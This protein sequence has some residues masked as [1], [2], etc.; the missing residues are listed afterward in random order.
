VRA[1]I[2]TPQREPS[3]AVTGQRS[4][5][6]VRKRRLEEPE[7]EQRERNEL[8]RKRADAKLEFAKSL[9]IM[10][11][12]QRDFQSRMLQMLETRFPPLTTS[13]T[14]ADNKSAERDSPS[15]QLI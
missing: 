2:A 12:N 8:R 5:S 4:S 15:N 7:E 9:R 1:E 13:T 14:E 3:P 11:E 10:Q 6:T